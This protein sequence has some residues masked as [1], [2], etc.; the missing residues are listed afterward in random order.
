MG[1]PSAVM[2]VFWGVLFFTTS[3]PATQSRRYVLTC[4]PASQSRRYVLTW[5]RPTN[6]SDL[7]LR[8]YRPA[9]HG[10]LCSR[11]YRPANH[12]LLCSWQG[13]LKNFE[14]TSV[15]EL[16][17]GAN[18]RKEDVTRLTWDTKEVSK[19]GAGTQVGK[20]KPV[21]KLT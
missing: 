9:N 20:R 5:N 13:L 11:V 3:V 21:L 14:P 1:G 4:V 8:V 16:L 6:H 17:L 7:Y 15:E 10:V 2:A 18:A 19:R 12:D